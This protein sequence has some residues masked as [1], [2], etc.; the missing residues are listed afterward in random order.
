M[1]SHLKRIA[2]LRRWQSPF[3]LPRQVLS[4]YNGERKLRKSIHI[5]RRYRKNNSDLFLR[6]GAECRTQS[7]CNTRTFIPD[8]GIH[9]RV[10]AQIVYRYIVHVKLM[11]HFFRLADA[12]LAKWTVSLALLASP[13][14]CSSMHKHRKP[15]LPKYSF[16]TEILG[17]RFF[18]QFSLRSAVQNIF[19]S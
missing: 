4:G 12:T 3:Q 5:C 15:G 16:S 1:S 17:F 9:G 6:Y 2:A 13:S 14:H 11:R 8:T 18:L 7:L 19:K 10:S